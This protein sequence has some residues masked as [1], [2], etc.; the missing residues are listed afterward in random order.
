M[1]LTVAIDRVL[2]IVDIEA[3]ELS[4]VTIDAVLV[5]VISNASESYSWVVSSSL[6]ASL[7]LSFRSDSG[8]NPVTHLRLMKIGVNTWNQNDCNLTVH[9]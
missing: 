3:F 8:I 2:E 9:Y 1:A 5:S 6:A 4:S 7:A